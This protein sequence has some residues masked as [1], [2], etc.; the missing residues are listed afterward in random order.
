MAIP[1]YASNGGIYAKD[2]NL[3]FQHLGILRPGLHPWAHYDCLRPIATEPGTQDTVELAAGFEDNDEAYSNYSFIKAMY[4]EPETIEFDFTGQS[5]DD[6]Y[7]YLDTVADE[8]NARYLG[9]LAIDTVSPDPE[10]YLVIAYVGY[11]SA[12]GVM[13]M[14]D[15]RS[16]GYSARVCGRAYPSETLTLGDTDTVIFDTEE[17]DAPLFPLDGY[18]GQADRYDTSTGVFTAMEQRTLLCTCSLHLASAARAAAATVDVELYH[19]KMPGLSPEATGIK[20]RYIVPPGGETAAPIITASGP[21]RVVEGDQL[22]WQAGN[23]GLGGGDTF[24]VAV[25]SWLAWDELGAAIAH[26]EPEV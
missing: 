1:T 9:V 4:G 18:G 14:V 3:V 17:Y 26:P 25:T 8:P 19:C 20:A 21:V 22:Y 13:S 16:F 11:N 2:M 23:S 7:L 6:Y 15:L 24:D 12:A 5:T 10:Q